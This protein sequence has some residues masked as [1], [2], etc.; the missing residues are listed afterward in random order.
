MSKKVLMLLTDGFEEME[1]ITPIDLLRRAE[2][3]VVTA[4]LDNMSVT[5]RQGVR[6]EA[7][8]L[9]EKVT[10]LYD[11]LILPGGPGYKT[12]AESDPVLKTVRGF[13]RD[14]IVCCAICAAPKVF[15]E[16]GILKGKTYTCYPGVSKEIFG[17]TYVDREVVQDGNIITSAGPGTA[18]RFSL[19]IIA[20]LAGE[21]KAN[22][23]K[24]QIIFNG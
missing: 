9:L 19:A 7:D 15:F 4:G 18:I 5:G 23:V 22:E 20:A 13:F 6:V 12:L 24:N 17:A 8:T 14:G 10:G 3:E 2:F 1:A 21:G 11:A 16:A